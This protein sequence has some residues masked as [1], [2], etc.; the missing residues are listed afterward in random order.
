VVDRTTDTPQEQS[1][2]HMFQALICFSFPSPVEVLFVLDVWI[3][4]EYYEESL[5]VELITIYECHV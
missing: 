1:D 2:K 4:A 5:N 3:P